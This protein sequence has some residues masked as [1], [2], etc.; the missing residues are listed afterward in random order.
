MKRIGYSQWPLTLDA[1]LKSGL[2]RITRAIVFGVEEQREGKYRLWLRQG[3]F[4]EASE[5]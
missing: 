4:A 2:K 3:N 1:S 5:A